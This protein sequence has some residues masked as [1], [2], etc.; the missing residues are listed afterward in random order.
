[1]TTE[2]KSQSKRKNGVACSSSMGK[3]KRKRIGEQGGRAAKSTPSRQTLTVNATESEAFPKISLSP[4]DNSNVLESKS[5]VAVDCKRSTS[6]KSKEAKKVKRSTRAADYHKPPVERS[7][8]YAASLRTRKGAPDPEEDDRPPSNTF[9]YK[10]NYQLHAT[11]ADTYAQGPFTTGERERIQHAIDLYLEEHAIPK[12]DLPLLITRRTKLTDTEGAPIEN[13]Y[14]NK[15]YTKWMLQVHRAARINRTLSQLMVYL[16]RTYNATWDCQPRKVKME[17]TEEADDRLR[18]LVL[19][20]MKWADIDREMGLRDNASRLRWRRIMF[21]EKCPKDIRERTWTKEEH[22]RLVTIVKEVMERD[23]IDDPLKFN[24]WS[25]VAAKFETRSAS[26]LRWQWYK[27]IASLSEFES[28]ETPRPVWTTNDDRELLSRMLA[29]CDGAYDESEVD[30]D[31]LKGED[32]KMWPASKLKERW[33]RARARVPDLESYTFIETVR[34]ALSLMP[35]PNIK[36]EEFIEDSDDEKIDQVELLPDT[37]DSEEEDL[38]F[39]IVRRDL[40]VRVEGAA[41]AKDQLNRELEFDRT[42]PIDLAAR[43]DIDIYDQEI[44]EGQDAELADEHQPLRADHADSARGQTKRSNPDESHQKGDIQHLQARIKKKK[45]KSSSREKNQ[46][47][48]IPERKKLKK[49][50]GGDALIQLDQAHATALHGSETAEKRKL[51]HSDDEKLQ[52]KKKKVKRVPV[53]K[54]TTRPNVQE[55]VAAS[56]SQQGN[57]SEKRAKIKKKKKKEQLSR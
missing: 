53:G 36:S 35:L 24:Q 56:T 45:K 17:W 25:L 6:D 40:Q 16:K 30:W 44:C 3:Q 52:K 10:K 27:N 55:N 51:Q 2:N 4:E 33:L 18:A 29:L 48:G 28:E 31:A 23:G 9:T 7:E 26:Q 46:S 43:P 41:N 14:A 11:F 1:M 37:L 15:R 20:G 19:R 57:G 5:H 22:E 50:G 47:Q 42:R 38:D 54:E 34:I 8:A 32:W 13:P 21:W 49:E 39:S 12:E